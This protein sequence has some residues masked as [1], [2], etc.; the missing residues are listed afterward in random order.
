MLWTKTPI[1]KTLMKDGLSLIPKQE[2]FKCKSKESA[3]GN[4]KHHMLWVSSFDMQVGQI[5]I[6]AGE[7]SSR[8]QSKIVTILL[9]VLSYDE[10]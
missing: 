7:M 3:R 8:E 9:F 5:A 10:I 2:E 4:H 6:Q 1:I